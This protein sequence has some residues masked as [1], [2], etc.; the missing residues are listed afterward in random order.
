MRGQADMTRL[1][2]QLGSDPAALSIGQ[3]T[4]IQF[5]ARKGHAEVVQILL[6]AT[7]ISEKLTIKLLRGAIRNRNQEIM[8]LL[9]ADPRSKVSG[10][11]LSSS[12]VCAMKSGNLPAAELLIN[13]ERDSSRILSTDLIEATRWIG[14]EAGAK[15][16]LER[17][18]LHSTSQVVL[19][20]ALLA[21]AYRGFEPVVR[22]L[23]DRGVHPN[24]EI[25]NDTPLGQAALAGHENTCRLLLNQGAHPD[26]G[27]AIVRAAGRG[28]EAIVRLLLYRGVDPNVEKD[29]DSPLREAALAGHENTCRLLLNQG[30]HPDSG[31]AIV[32]AAGAG[33]EAIVM[34][35][36]ERGANPNLKEQNGGDALLNAACGGSQ[37]IVELLLQLGAD[38]RVQDRQ[39]AAAAAGV[40]GGVNIALAKFPPLADT[41]LADA[42]SEIGNIITQLNAHFDGPDIQA[43][44]QLFA[45]TGYWREHRV[46]VI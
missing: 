32:R 9:L 42:A 35:L 33:H 23:L 34:L 16:L 3:W 27:S 40:R 22:L 29:N 44:A 5:A 30:A 1:L 10:A 14:N 12:M 19:V 45:L 31:S 17:A 4:P 15:F 37:I 39:A 46:L 38:P 6:D 13:S 43:A 24:V 11:A 36:L 20:C 28:H 18:A 21:A 41:G 26:S 2:L 8:Q 25:D 7:A